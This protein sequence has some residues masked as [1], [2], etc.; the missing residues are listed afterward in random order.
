M[1]KEKVNK[2]ALQIDAEMDLH[3]FFEREAIEAVSE[4]LKRAEAKSFSRVRIIT[5]KGKGVLQSGV[6]TWLQEQK[7]IFETAKINEGGSGALIVNL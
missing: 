4:F 2:F 6:R 5:G 7:Y 1:R 3:G